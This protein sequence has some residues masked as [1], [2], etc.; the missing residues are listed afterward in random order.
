MAASA[1]QATIPGFHSRLHFFPIHHSMQFV[2]ERL[3]YV[4]FEHYL[5]DIVFGPNPDGYYSAR[6]RYPHLPAGHTTC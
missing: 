2:D 5:Q 6:V 4:E 3:E 1:S